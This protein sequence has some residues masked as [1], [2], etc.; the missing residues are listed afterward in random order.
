[1]ISKRDAFCFHIERRQTRRVLVAGY[2]FFLAAYC[3][4]FLVRAQHHGFL[5]NGSD[6]TVFLIPAILGGVRYGGAVKPFRSPVFVPLM[7]RSDVGT[8]FG[9]S[10]TRGFETL[11]PLDERETNLRDR[12]HFVAYSVCRWLAFLLFVLYGILGLI[13]PVWLSAVGPFLFVVLTLTLWSLPQSIILWTEP[14]LEE[15]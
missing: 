1:M 13:K 5:F 3:G 7:E 11:E 12:V 4:A 6:L 14:D 10:S 8:I 9:R 2:W 15:A